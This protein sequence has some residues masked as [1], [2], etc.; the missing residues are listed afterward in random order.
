MPSK[1]NRRKASRK[2]KRDIINQAIADTA[3]I[4]AAKRGLQLASNKS[5]F[6]DD[7]NHLLEKPTSVEELS[8]FKKEKRK[9]LIEQFK[10]GLDKVRER[11][12][13]PDLTE[14]CVKPSFKPSKTLEDKN[15]EKMARE[16]KHKMERSSNIIENINPKKRKASTA[17]ISFWDENEVKKKKENDEKLLKESFISDALVKQNQVES[18]V[19]EA[20]RKRAKKPLKSAKVVL[21]LPGQSYNPDPNEHKKVIELAHL[22]EARLAIRAEQVVESFVVRDKEELAAT[23]NDE[24]DGLIARERPEEP[25]D[26]STVQYPPQPPRIKKPKPTRK[27]AI[28]IAINRRNEKKRELRTKMHTETKNIPLIAKTLEEREKRQEQLR[29]MKKRIREER[30]RIK[31]GLETLPVKGVADI[32][33]EEEISGSLRKQNNNSW[34]LWYDR[35]SAH[36]RSKIIQI[37][38]FKKG[39]I[40]YNS[41]P[42]E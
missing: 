10:D 41:I 18:L 31:K 17:L 33:L 37:D 24:L 3:K 9:Q 20:K 27:K 15:L 26:P 13:Q 23:G 11:V 38:S 34:S 19:L 1:K 40:R 7:K 32:Q 22:Q 8:Q 30:I 6:L 42:V 39:N 4:N 14:I 25:Q 2:Q 36:H 16:L 5:L 21:P 35:L 12:M 28:G 29:D